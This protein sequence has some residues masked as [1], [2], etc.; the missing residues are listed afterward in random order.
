MTERRQ[1]IFGTVAVALVGA[2]T[3]AECGKSD[4]IK[5][6]LLFFGGDMTQWPENLE[7]DR[8][9]LLNGV[10]TPWMVT[11]GNHDMGNS[12]TR[13][14]LDRF[15]KV[16][17]HDREARDVKGWRIIAGNSQFWHPTELKD[18][19]AA[20]EAWLAGELTLGDSSGYD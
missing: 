6:D 7:A 14:N 5:P 12:V 16:F 4:E 20:Y 9:R 11:P 8:P 2:A 15:R 19:R 13:T 3:A 18:E 1:L 17:G 10:K